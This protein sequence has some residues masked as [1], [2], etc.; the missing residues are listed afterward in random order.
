MIRTV[1]YIEHKDSGDRIKYYTTLGGARI[2][3]RIRNL[4]LGFDQ[5][6]AR[7]TRDDRELEL[8]TIDNASVEGTYTIVED[9]IEQAD[10]EE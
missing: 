5:R 8:Y 6:T 1:Y 4:K 3:M 2:A 10:L 9:L 7:I